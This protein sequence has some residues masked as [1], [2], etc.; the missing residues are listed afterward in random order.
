MQQEWYSLVLHRYGILP[1]IQLEFTYSPMPITDPMFIFHMNLTKCLFQNTRMVYFWSTF[2]K[3]NAI[4][5][6]VSQNYLQI[7]YQ[8]RLEM[9][10]YSI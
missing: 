2:N 7:Y 1:I 5:Y 6:R 10:W 4:S 3:N 8:Y 9:G